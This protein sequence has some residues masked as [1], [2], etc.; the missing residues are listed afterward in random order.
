MLIQQRL[1]RR[2]PD[3]KGSQITAH[4]YN[5][6]GCSVGIS[7]PNLLPFPTPVPDTQ[8]L[9]L[10]MR[11]VNFVIIIPINGAGHSLIEPHLCHTTKWTG[12]CCRGT[13]TPESRRITRTLCPHYRPRSAWGYGQ[14]L[15]FSHWD[16][17]LLVT[18]PA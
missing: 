16:P 12:V 10:L 15:L 1:R 13:L 2:F 7:C 4:F 3:Y 17:A 8:P 11:A 5:K 18:L 9:W 6:T 14:W